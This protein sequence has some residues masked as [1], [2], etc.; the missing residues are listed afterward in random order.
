V[1]SAWPILVAALGG[2]LIASATTLAATARAER[3]AKA[4][5][6]DAAAESDKQRAFLADE[7]QKAREAGESS[8]AMTRR[9]SAYR[10]LIDRSG[11]LAHKMH[12]LGEWARDDLGS[13]RRVTSNEKIDQYNWWATDVASVRE[14]QVR[15]WTEGTLEGVGLGNRIWRQC[16]V[17]KDIAIIGIANPT[18][19]AW[20]A[21]YSSA[22]DE[23]NQMRAEL[24]ALARDG[25]GLDAFD[26]LAP[27]G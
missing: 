6:A 18:D 11:E 26:V 14:A 15:V 10:D 20:L 17:L 22:S 8:A 16:D 13:G 23:L 4:A 7:A 24:V 25:R 19:R 21:T 12:V 3:S 27:G 9:T 5:R 1:G 2:A